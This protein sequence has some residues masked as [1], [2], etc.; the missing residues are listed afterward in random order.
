L[1]KFVVDVKNVSKVFGNNV[2]ALDS[3]SLSIESGEF[4]SLLGPSGC[5]KTTLLRMIAGFESP[6]TG[7]IFLDGQDVDNVPPYKRP[8]NMVF[9]SYALFPHMTVFEN[10]AFGLRMASSTLSKKEK[11]LEIKTKVDESLAMVR[12]ADFSNRYPA[13]LSGGQQQRIA[14]AR[15]FVNKPKVLLLDEPLSALDLKIRQ[16][17]QDELKRLHRVLGLTFV[18]VTH[19]QGEALAL[20]DRIAVFNK[21]R[22]EQI[23]SPKE[24]YNHPQTPFVANF[25]G[26]SNFLKAKVVAKTAKGCLLSLGELNRQI[27]VDSFDGQMDASYLNEGSNLVLCVRTEHIK[28]VDHD[29]D[30]ASG[31]LKMEGTIVN[32]VYQGNAVDYVLE[33][34]SS[35]FEASIQQAQIQ[36][37]ENRTAQVK[38]HIKVSVTNGEGDK[39]NLSYDVGQKASVL[40]DQR[41]IVVML[42][43]EYS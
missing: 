16:E 38:K 32:S 5:G 13:Q 17:M 33:I 24:I 9:Q 23:A 40:V 29:G 41:R 14:L 21:G 36:S 39:K 37:A 3:V 1:S 30:V 12:L 43:P 35:E 18:M 34:A 42:D 7:S 8:V 4:I 6:S 2:K 26:E 15:A 20:S 22:I 31:Y 25:I 10:V 19:D 28:L 11:E 27:E